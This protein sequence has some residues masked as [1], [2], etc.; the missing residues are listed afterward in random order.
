MQAAAIDSGAHLVW[1]RGGSGDA[2]ANDDDDDD[3]DSGGEASHASSSSSSGSSSNATGNTTDAMRFTLDRYDARNLLDCAAALRK[4]RRFAQQHRAIDA[5]DATVETDSSKV[6]SRASSVERAVS[7][8]TDAFRRAWVVTKAD[9]SSSPNAGNA[10]VSGS[11][12]GGGADDDAAADDDDD[13]DDDESSRAN[14][15]ALDIELA[16]A[17]Q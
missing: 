8:R 7:T 15:T 17:C 6:R 3:A 4:Y 9:A 2:L 13:D 11:R 1:W 12:A 16:I 5:S 14:G 10:C